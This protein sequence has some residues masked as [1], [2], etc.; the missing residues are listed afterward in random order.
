MRLREH[1]VLN[2]YSIRGLGKA[3]QVSAKSI[4]AVE[5]GL[6]RPSLATIRKLSTFL[7]IEPTEVDEFK[8]ALGMAIKGKKRPTDE[9]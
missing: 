3:A 9:P 1:R 4:W 7:E 2:L 8:E 5:S 6:W